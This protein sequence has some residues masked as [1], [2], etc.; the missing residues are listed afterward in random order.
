MSKNLISPFGA[1]ILE[2]LPDKWVSALGK[3]I[4]NGYVDKY[5]NIN[6]NGM[7]NI[8]NTKK[9]IIFI[10]N[11]LSNSDGLV[12]NKILKDEDVTYVAGV[13]LF[14][15][16][17]TNLIIRIAKTTPLRP[18]TADKEG[19][20][21]IIK[22]LK[23]GGNIA[24]FPE[25]TRSRS[26]KMLKARRGIYLIIKLSGASVI[27]IGLSGTEKL[28]P[29]N[30][31]DMG[32]EKFHNARVNVNIGSA[33]KIPEKMQ[34]EGRH[35]YEDRVVSHMMRSIAELIPEEYRGEYAEK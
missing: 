21:K 10:A 20:E 9:P 12:L 17:V 34:G 4:A 13:K 33:I 31:D 15:N 14:E 29:V 11:H 27:P 2:L 3:K 25:G 16:P 24:I 7:E 18:N 28:L 32:R 26:G 6:L 8:K 35:D 30:D 1:K 19:I 22:I 5:A 23:E